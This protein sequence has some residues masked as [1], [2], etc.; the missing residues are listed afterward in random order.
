MDHD[1]IFII[2]GCICRDTWKDTPLFPHV[3]IRRL[4]L[5]LNVREKSSEGSTFVWSWIPPLF[6]REINVCGTHPCW[7]SLHSLLL[8]LCLGTILWSV[9]PCKDSLFLLKHDSHLISVILLVGSFNL[10]A[11]YIS[12][13]MYFLFP[14][15]VLHFL[16][17]LLFGY[18]WV[19]AW[20]DVCVDIIWQLVGVSTTPQK[21]VSSEDRSQAARCDSWYLTHEP[22]LWPLIQLQCMHDLKTG[23][24]QDCELCSMWELHTSAYTVTS[25]NSA[26]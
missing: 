20:Q 16:V 19:C 21:N 18:A 24:L 11:A 9:G 12:L 17:C 5:H 15:S 10:L 4:D 7:A 23:I 22:S 2:N 14:R 25:W 1:F 26:T 3:K 6:L 13:W 8:T